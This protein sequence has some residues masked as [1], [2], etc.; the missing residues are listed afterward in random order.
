[1]SWGARAGA[2]AGGMRTP[3]L[4][5]ATLRKE[6]EMLQKLQDIEDVDALV[7]LLHNVAVSRGCHAYQDPATGYQVMYVLD[8]ATRVICIQ[9]TRWTNSW[10]HTACCIYI[11]LLCCDH[12]DIDDGRFLF[13]A[14]R[15]D[16]PQ[17]ETA[18]MLWERMQV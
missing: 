3:P 8:T 5:I 9:P 10:L 11:Y 4:S 7:R 1:M 14:R 2:A 6:P 13:C 17:A 15:Q 18:P 12:T 16:V